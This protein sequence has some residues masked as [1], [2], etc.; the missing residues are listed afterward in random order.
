ML[1][2]GYSDVWRPQKHC[3]GSTGTCP[4]GLSHL[5]K[6]KCLFQSVAGTH[7]GHPRPGS[8]PLFP[9]ERGAASRRS[10]GN[11]GCLFQETDR[12]RTHSFHQGTC[13]QSGSQMASPSPRAPDQCFRHFCCPALRIRLG[14]LRRDRIKGRML[15]HMV[16]LGDG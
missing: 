10:L 8:G 13:G 15:K 5:Q 14:F 9:K 7:K 6:E 1:G 11:S 3:L 2:E 4:A 12:H 16:L